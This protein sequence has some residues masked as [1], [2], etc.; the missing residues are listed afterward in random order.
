VSRVVRGGP[1]AAGRSSSARPSIPQCA[2]V[3]FLDAEIAAVEKLI[4]AEAL[5]WP[6]MKRLMTV[7]GAKI[8]ANPSGQGET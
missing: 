2:Q 5:S 8:L 1:A 7:P 6:K 4:A 3:D